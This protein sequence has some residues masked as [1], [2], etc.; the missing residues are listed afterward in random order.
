MSTNP[1]RF[2]FL[3]TNFVN[4]VYAI[5][6]PEIIIFGSKNS[7]IFEN[8]YHKHQKLSKL[9]VV[10]QTTIHYM[11]VV[12]K[13][14]VLDVWYFRKN[15]KNTYHLVI[16]VFLLWVRRDICDP[17]HQNR[18]VVGRMHFKILLHLYGKKAKKIKRN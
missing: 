15:I 5:I 1:T 16:G 8:S 12:S 3:L 10:F 7:P 2:F 4:L 13:L 17:S 18:A 6:C 9:E 11:Q 14:L